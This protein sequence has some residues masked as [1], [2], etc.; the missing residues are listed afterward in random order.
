MYLFQ[1]IRKGMKKYM[2]ML[3]HW[4]LPDDDESK[5]D[6]SEGRKSLSILKSQTAFYG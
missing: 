6:N 2:N 5:S 4:K 1:V 3:I